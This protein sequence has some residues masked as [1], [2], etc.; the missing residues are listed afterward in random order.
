MAEIDLYDGL[1]KYRRKSLY[2]IARTAG[3]QRKNLGFDYSQ[4]IFKKTMSPHILRSSN[5]SDFVQFLND[6]FVLL[7]NSTKKMRIFRNYTVD[8]DYK[9][10]D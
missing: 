5:I 6:W 3:E 7:I 2:G 1:Y 4:S 10:I 8:K 9:H